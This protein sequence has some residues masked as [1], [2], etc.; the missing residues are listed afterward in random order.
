MNDTHQPDCYGR[1]F[2]DLLHLPEGRPARGRVFTVLLERV[3][4]M[5]R[6]GRSVAA[7]LA[8]WEE[9]RRCPRVEDCYKLSMAKLALESAV[10]D[11]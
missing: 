2:P 4:G 3:G 6:G 1:M 5:F 9:C 7:D 10:Q 11:Q 8:A